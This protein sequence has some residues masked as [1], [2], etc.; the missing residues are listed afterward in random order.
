MPV[1]RWRSSDY[2]FFTYTKHCVRWQ[3]IKTFTYLGILIIIGFL[4]TC[5]WFV[6]YTYL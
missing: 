2:S 4:D 1:L 5:Y 3:M 6:C